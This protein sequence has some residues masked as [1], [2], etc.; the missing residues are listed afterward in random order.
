MT[1]SEHVPPL[2]P[3]RH[4]GTAQRVL[5]VD[6]DRSLRELLT[7]ALSSDGWDVRTAEDG[8]EGV[9]VARAFRPDAVLLDVLLPDVSGFEVLGRLRAE[10]PGLR[11]LFLSARDDEED[12]IAGLTAG[13]DD[14][15]PKPFRLE[16]VTSRLRTLLRR[17]AE[18]A[19]PSGVLAIGDLT[20]DDEWHTAIRGG[21]VIPLS[22][23]EYR[24]LRYLVRN[25]RRVLPRDEILAW[26]WP[27]DF[28][29]RSAVVDVCMSA[30]CRKIDA[31]CPP[32]IHSVPGVGYRLEPAP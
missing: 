6:R 3:I 17:P 5:V 9:E 23:T 26:V 15:I 18:G 19:G 21:D 2:Q 20:L 1:T 13:A 30:L 32:M 7:L 22:A 31:R 4:D 16:D 25:A 12:R 10:A 14:H 8:A 11:V 28:G 29:G 24:L 27:Y